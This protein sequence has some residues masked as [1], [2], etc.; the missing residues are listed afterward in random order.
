[1]KKYLLLF[2]LLVN[3]VQGQ[4][5]KVLYAI[6]VSPSANSVKTEQKVFIE[7]LLKNANLQEFQLLFNSTSSSFKSTE[8]MITLSAYEEQINT[9]AKLAFTSADEIYFNK[10]EQIE[11]I[12]K[13]DGLIVK[14]ENLSSN[15]TLT[16]NSKLIGSYLC[17]EGIL[18]RTFINRQGETK[19]EEIIAWFAPQLPYPYGPKNF[20]GLPGL[21]LELH[22]KKTV[23]SAK[24]IEL[25]R[26]DQK[27]YFPKGKTISKE[28]YEKKLES[29][30]GGVLIGK[31]REKEQ[32]SQ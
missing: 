24:N 10:K 9:I 19:I 18:K 12:R 28:E 32:N 17:Y 11:Y 20:H 14:D 4:S 7:N 1:M 25:I 23:Y 3:L 16:T 22:E 2:L 27:I 5:G 29:S 6:Q 31:K 13:E 21:I 8:S 26:D 30:L 15:W